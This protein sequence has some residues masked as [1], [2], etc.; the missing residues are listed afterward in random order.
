MITRATSLPF[1]LEQ[2]KTAMT[3]VGAPPAGRAAGP[4]VLATQ[5]TES[6]APSSICLADTADGFPGTNTK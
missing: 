1:T 5:A 4:A 2:Q 3:R 6:A